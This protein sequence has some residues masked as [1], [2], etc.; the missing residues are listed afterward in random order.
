MLAHT[1]GGAVK[2]NTLAAVSAKRTEYTRGGRKVRRL[3]QS[4]TRLR[5]LI[6]SAQLDTDWMHPWTGLD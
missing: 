4:F 6:M 1:Q 2:T 3:T 5:A